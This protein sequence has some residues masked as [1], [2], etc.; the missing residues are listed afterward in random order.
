MGLADRAQARVGQSGLGRA[1]G[2]SPGR[3][4]EVF[5]F[6]NYLKPFAVQ[7]QLQ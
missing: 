1:F 6:L 5:V 3:K 4:G 2:L 7:K